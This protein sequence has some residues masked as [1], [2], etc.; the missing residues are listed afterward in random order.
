ME[1]AQW[2]PDE[3]QLAPIH[4][5]EILK[6]AFMKPMNLMA[7]LQGFSEHGLKR[8]FSRLKSGE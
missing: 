7:D 4:S 8:Q 6:E 1:V 3:A 5:R 2:R